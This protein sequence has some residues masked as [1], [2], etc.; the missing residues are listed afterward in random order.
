MNLL[1]DV[2]ASV[3]LNGSGNGS[4]QIGPSVVRERWQPASA[5][6][7]VT[8]NTKEAACDLYLGTG[9]LASQQIAQTA[10]GSS[11]DTCALSGIDMPPGMLLIAI[12]TGGDPGAMAVL[13][14]VGNRS[15]P[16]V[17]R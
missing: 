15:R 9:I 6:V 4:V 3:I 14:V 7:S 13:H 1:L 5:F 17:S 16:E 2:S 12:W 8:T 11:G 10:T